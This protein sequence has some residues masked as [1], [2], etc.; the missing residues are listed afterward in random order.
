[1]SG[2]RDVAVVSRGRTVVEAAEASQ[3]V[4]ETD[5]ALLFTGRWVFP[6]VVGTTTGADGWTGV[7]S[8]RTVRLAGGGTIGEQLTAHR[9]GE[10][11]AYDLGRFPR[12]LD[13]LVSGARSEVRFRPGAGGGTEL[14]WRFVFHP[15]PFRRPMAGLLLAGPW[16]R[17]LD[18]VVARTVGLLDARVA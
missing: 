1:M 9:P 15:R 13:L 8:T 14:I 3:R 6:A 11:Y 5:P 18:D 4:L 16:R 2:R 12:P 17:Y 10:I 7:G